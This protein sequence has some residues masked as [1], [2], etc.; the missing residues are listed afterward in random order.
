MIK[1]YFA[2]GAAAALSNSQ[3]AL[4]SVQNQAAAA[5]AFCLANDGMPPAGYFVIGDGP[6]LGPKQ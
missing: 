5:Q 4:A 3:A 2:D 6:V 1:A